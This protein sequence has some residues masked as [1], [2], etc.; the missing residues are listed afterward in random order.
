[1]CS[2]E[3]MTCGIN[4][5]DSSSVIQSGKFTSVWGPSFYQKETRNPGQVRS[6]NAD[7]RISCRQVL[8]RNSLPV[9]GIKLRSLGNLYI[10]KPAVIRDWE[11]DMRKR[12]PCS[13]EGPFSSESTWM[14]ILCLNIQSER[15]CRK[16]DSQ[17]GY[18]LAPKHAP[19]TGDF[20]S[21]IN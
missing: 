20:S 8:L 15:N 10:S 13:L 14:E 16:K 21:D 9:L 4:S 11:H 3:T 12:G 6:R 7:V 19:Q 18:H 5:K 17:F 1:M 2:N